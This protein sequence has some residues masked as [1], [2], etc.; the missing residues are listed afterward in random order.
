M[1][2]LLELMQGKKV[3]TVEPL[4]S[5]FK[6][7]EE[8]T[9]GRLRIGHSCCT[10]SYLLKGEPPPDRFHCAT[11]LTVKHILL[12]NIYYCQIVFGVK[13]SSGFS[14]RHRFTQI[15]PGVLISSSEENVM[16]FRLMLLSL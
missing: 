12:S 9:L 3:Q 5:R 7:R 10:H 13:S 2:T 4:P 15:V 1:V 11:T 16:V 14:N 8:G 6:C